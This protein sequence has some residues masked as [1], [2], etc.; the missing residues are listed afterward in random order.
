[1]R[2]EVFEIVQKMDKDNIRTQMALQCAVD[3]RT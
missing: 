2:Q 1:M 3:Y